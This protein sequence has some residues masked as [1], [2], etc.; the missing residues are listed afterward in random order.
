MIIEVISQHT[1]HNSSPDLAFLLTSFP[2]LEIAMWR[3]WT[4][5]IVFQALWA[6]GLTTSCERP[7]N[8]NLAPREIN[9]ICPEGLCDQHAEG[10][11]C[12]CTVVFQDQEPI[13][14]AN[15]QNKVRAVITRNMCWQENSGDEDIYYEDCAE[16]ADSSCHFQDRIEICHD[17]DID[18]AQAMC[19][20]FN[21]GDAFGATASANQR[22]L[23]TRTRSD[24]AGRT[25]LA[26]LKCPVHPEDL[27]SCQLEFLP[28]GEQCRQMVAWCWFS[29]CWPPEFSIRATVSSRGVS[30]GG[31]GASV[32]QLRYGQAC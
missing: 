1:Y 25:R 22:L 3:L 23:R 13:P 8:I 32:G 4:F 12:Y 28:V 29:P 14:V 26:R 21:K 9:Q 10:E 11:I 6:F 2:P 19:R 15:T 7:S 31:T 20:H 5:S 18:S 17:D 27:R 16:N 24:R 30:S